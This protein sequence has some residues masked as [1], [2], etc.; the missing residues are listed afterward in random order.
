MS[1]RRRLRGLAGIAA[2]AAVLATGLG[3]TTANA[4]SPS[5]FSHF[6]Q[7]HAVIQAQVT[8]ADLADGWARHQREIAGHVRPHSP[9]HGHR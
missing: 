8:V 1:A 7:L 3:S 9:R 4:A 6:P 2:T 5:A